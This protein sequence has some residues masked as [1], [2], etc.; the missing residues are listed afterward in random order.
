[1][2]VCKLRRLL[3]PVE[4]VVVIDI[5]GPVSVSGAEHREDRFEVGGLLMD[6]EPE[7]LHCM[8]GSVL[9]VEA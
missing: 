9:Q 1:M 7:D 5:V 8:Q 2:S 4:V 6:L 3:W